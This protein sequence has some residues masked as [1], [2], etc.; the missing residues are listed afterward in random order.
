MAE[1][2]RCRLFGMAHVSY[3][4]ISILTVAPLLNSMEFS[5]KISANTQAV[6][7]Y[8][9]N[10]LTPGAH[11]LIDLHYGFIV[12]TALE[13]Q[14]T[15]VVKHLFEKNCKIV[16]LSTS[17]NGPA[18]FRQFQSATPDIFANRQYGIDYVF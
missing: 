17:I 8:I 13:P 11:I 9:E 7:D 18:M 6:Y 4:L 15:A 1:Q 5:V 14:L 3:L 16:F 10:T 2:E 12:R